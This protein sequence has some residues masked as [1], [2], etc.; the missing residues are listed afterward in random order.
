MISSLPP[1]PTTLATDQSTSLPPSST[2]STSVPI[3]EASTMAYSAQTFSSSPLNP[4]APV[5]QAPNTNRTGIKKK[6]SSG[7]PKTA[8]DVEISLLKQELVIAKTKLLELESENKDKS[9]KLK[10]LSDTISLYE[11]EETQSLKQKYFGDHLPPS[12]APNFSSTSPSC[13]S[14]IPHNCSSLDSKTLNRV[15]NYF[16][17]LT[18]K[19]SSPTLDPSIPV[20]T[21]N[22]SMMSP[23]Q[24]QSGAPAPSKPPSKPLSPLIQEVSDP[25]AQSHINPVDSD[26]PQPPTP[27]AHN[28]PN[29]PQQTE[30]SQ[31]NDSNMT[32][33]EFTADGIAEEDHLNFQLLTTQ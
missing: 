9:R 5:F 24:Q 23:N 16:L 3:P 28:L 10:I 8:Q 32:I 12:S 25:A 4:R 11:K 33:D 6:N 27:P 18:Q 29:Q 14:S 13:V 26:L 7:P 19:S 30:D 2:A 20:T 22:S 17:D 31:S 1:A 21:T 15:L